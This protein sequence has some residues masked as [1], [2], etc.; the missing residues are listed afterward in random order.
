MTCLLAVF[1][2]AAATAI[3]ASSSRPGGLVPH[4]LNGER[5]VTGK[6]TSGIAAVA[7]DRHLNSSSRSGASLCKSDVNKEE[8][9]YELHLITIGNL[10][11]SILKPQKQKRV[12]A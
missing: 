6:R 1:C 12:T 9:K 11:L 8:H 3:A 5:A 7:S 10:K 2:L 4:T